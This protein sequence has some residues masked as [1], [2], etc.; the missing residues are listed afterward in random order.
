LN[1]YYEINSKILILKIYDIFYLGNY[2]HFVFLQRAWHPTK[3]WRKV[4][5]EQF[6]LR[7]GKS[8]ENSA[9]KLTNRILKY[10]NQKMHVG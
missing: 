4:V 9:F 3:R 7:Q 10:I 2:I 1:G 6:D 5:A 8:A